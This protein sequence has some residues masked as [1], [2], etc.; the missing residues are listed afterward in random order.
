MAEI[1]SVREASGN[2]VKESTLSKMRWRWIVKG[3]IL[4]AKI[5][6]AGI[7]DIQGQKRKSSEY[8]LEG[9]GFFSDADA[10]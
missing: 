5:N 2:I 3:E 7:S 6:V 8:K 9:T 10:R 1:V 4:N